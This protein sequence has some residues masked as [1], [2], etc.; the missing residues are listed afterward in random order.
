MTNN[1]TLIEVTYQRLIWW[2]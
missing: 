2:F 1:A